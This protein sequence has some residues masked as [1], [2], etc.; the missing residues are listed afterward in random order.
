MIVPQYVT[1]ARGKHYVTVWPNHLLAL[2]LYLMWSYIP[3]LYSNQ[4]CRNKLLM[5]FSA[6]WWHIGKNPVFVWSNNSLGLSAPS[7]YQY[8]LYVLP[9]NK[10][11]HRKKMK[12]LLMW[13]CSSYFNHLMVSMWTK[14]QG[15]LYGLMSE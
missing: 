4:Y 1:G 3:A 13:L 15:P 10:F 11:I 9:L 12:E 14:H 7:N 6:V 5:T 2:I 8:V